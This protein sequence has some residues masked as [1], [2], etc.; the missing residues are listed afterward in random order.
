MR[1]F[2]LP[3]PALTMSLTPVASAPI[4]QG[5]TRYTLSLALLG[6]LLLTPACRYRSW[7][8]VNGSHEEATPV[9]ELTERDFSHVSPTRRSR[10]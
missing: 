2:R 10:R 1:I 3:S 6:L 9:S 7:Q 5:M 8:H 4:I